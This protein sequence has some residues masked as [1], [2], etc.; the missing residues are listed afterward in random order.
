MRVGL[1]GLALVTACAASSRTVAAPT[2][3][4][5]ATAREGATYRVSVRYDPA[6]SEWVPVSVPRMPLHHASRLTFV[7]L[8]EH[9]ELDRLRATSAQL[10]IVLGRADIHRIDE[11]EWTAE[12]PAR[13][14]DVET[15]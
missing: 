14:V 9:P 8:A 11:R 12:Y 15:R 3:D 13:I 2:L 1:V 4:D 6:R 7:N 10:T 5:Y